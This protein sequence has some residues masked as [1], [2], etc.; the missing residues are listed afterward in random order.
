[1]DADDL[2]PPENVTKMANRTPTPTAGR[3]WLLAVR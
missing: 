2:H 3:G 1:V